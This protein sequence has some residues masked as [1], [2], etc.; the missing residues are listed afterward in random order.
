MPEWIVAEKWERVVH[1]LPI[2]LVLLHLFD[3]LISSTELVQEDSFGGLS[4]VVRGVH[5]RK[6]RGDDWHQML[7]VR[8]ICLRIPGLETQDSRHALDNLAQQHW[9]RPVPLI[10]GAKK[11]IDQLA[12]AVVG[13]QLAHA[14]HQESPSDASEESQDVR[15]NPSPLCPA[16]YEAQSFSKSI[17]I[18]HQLQDLVRNSVTIDASDTLLIHVSQYLVILHGLLHIL[19]LQG[20][21]QTGEEKIDA[22]LPQLKLDNWRIRAGDGYAVR[23]MRV[24]LQ[25]FQEGT[26]KRLSCNVRRSNAQRVHVTSRLDHAK[27]VGAEGDDSPIA[28]SLHALASPLLQDPLRHNSLKLLKHF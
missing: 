10:V 21:H 28:G 1:L 3:H 27:P 16:L 14:G 25:L 4:N 11:P 12:E 26:E 6:S 23:D 7:L 24:L 18:W 8:E 20:P 19:P 9:L 13:V 17:L 5:G 22:N 2:C 15:V